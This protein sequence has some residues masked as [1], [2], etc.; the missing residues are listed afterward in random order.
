MEPLGQGYLIIS[1]SGCSGSP[2]ARYGVPFLADE[3]PSTSR[4]TPRSREVQGTNPEPCLAIISGSISAPNLGCLVYNGESVI[5][6]YIKHKRPFWKGMVRGLLL[7][8]DHPP[9]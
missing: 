1:G 7:M 2:I 5:A 3:Y 6:T 8:D 9:R 4:T